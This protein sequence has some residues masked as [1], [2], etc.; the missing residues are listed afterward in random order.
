M[1]VD[2]WIPIYNQI[3]A[4]FGYSLERD[5]YSAELLG[6]VRGS[7]SLEPLRALE[8]QRVE[9]LG[10]LV[11]ECHHETIIAAGSALSQ[12]ADAGCVPTLLVTDLDGD[13]ALQL[14]YNLRGVPAVIHAHGDN[15]D[16]IEGWA[17]RFTGPVISTC[18]CRPPRGTFNFGGFTDGDRAVFM[19]DH[20][21]AREIVLNGWNF[22]DPHEP[23][24][25]KKRKLEWAER[26]VDMV[27][28]PVTVL[29]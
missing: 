11:R 4:D 18:Q 10:P 9:I 1:E 21:R 3:L 8:G 7:D 26:L 16:L 29:P 28:T 6:R 14:E 17:P 27:A 24:N 12:A 23:G 2:A 13:T 22:E 25:I 15:M 5:R 19:A 20:F